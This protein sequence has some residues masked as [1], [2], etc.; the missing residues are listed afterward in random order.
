MAKQKKKRKLRFKIIILF[1]ILILIIA[2]MI[3]YI[4]NLPIQNIYIEGNNII[5]EEEIISLAK[6]ENY[7]SFILTTKNKIAKDI[8]NNPYINNVNIEKKLWGKLYIKIEEYKVIG[9]NTNQKVILSNQKILDNTYLLTDLPYLTKELE[10]AVFQNFITKFTKVD[11]NIL[12]QISQIEYAPV[13]VDE[14]R[15][16]LYMDDGNE[17]YI[18][19]TKIEKLNKYNEII[20]KMDGL[21]GIIYLD[22]GDYI[23]IKNKTEIIDVSQKEDEDN[24]EE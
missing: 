16:L 18:T 14:E 2:Y 17:V 8:K 6:L 13:E 19:L 3:Y 7:P 24:S 9:I 21:E 15:F 22:S 12:R 11:N 1:I 10:E 5:T 23:E 20:K 4:I